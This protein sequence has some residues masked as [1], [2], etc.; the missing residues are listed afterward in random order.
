MLLDNAPRLSTEAL[1]ENIAKLASREFCRLRPRRD[2]E[3][4]FL[5]IKQGLVKL[6]P[7]LAGAGT[8]PEPATLADGVNVE[9]GEVSAGARLWGVH[10]ESVDGGTAGV[11]GRV[12]LKIDELAGEA[13]AWH[14]ER[15]SGT[16]Q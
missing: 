2:T 15:H 13:H 4:D 6:I 5:L 1:P 16:S 11:P 12:R 3:H 9:V 8:W 14:N 10:N 7:S